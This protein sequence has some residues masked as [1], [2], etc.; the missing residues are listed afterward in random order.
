MK[1]LLHSLGFGEVSL[2]GGFLS[3]KKLR[4]KEQAMA[5]SMQLPVRKDGWNLLGLWL[6]T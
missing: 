5:G 6:V 1:T 3:P 2:H 4:S